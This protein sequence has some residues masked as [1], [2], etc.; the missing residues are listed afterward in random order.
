MQEEIKRLRAELERIMSGRLD[1]YP[2]YDYLSWE[3][4]AELVS[5]RIDELEDELRSDLN[6]YE[7][8]ELEEERRYLCLSQGIS[9]WS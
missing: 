9:R 8:D 5:R 7:G 6:G 2:E 1:E 3:E 4:A